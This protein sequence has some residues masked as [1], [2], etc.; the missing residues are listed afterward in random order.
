MFIIH[1]FLLFLCLRESTIR[2]TP[3]TAGMARCNFLR[4]VFFLFEVITF[5]HDRMYY[6]LYTVFRFRYTLY[7]FK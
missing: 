3:R 2:E 6:A 5:R 1:F 7:L 4:F